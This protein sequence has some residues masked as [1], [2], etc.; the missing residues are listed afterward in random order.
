MNNIRISGQA[1]IIHVCMLLFV[2]CFFVFFANKR[3]KLFVD[4]NEKVKEMHPDMMTT[5]VGLAKKGNAFE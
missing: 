4:S 1:Q 5:L 2:I 3:P